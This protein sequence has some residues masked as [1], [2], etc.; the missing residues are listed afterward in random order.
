MYYLKGESM[1]IKVVEKIKK[2]LA[3]SESSNEHEAKVSLL[4]AQELLAKHKLSLKEVKEFKIYNNSIKE[5][6]STVS[7]TKAKWKAKLARVIA[8]NFGCYYYFKTRRS[9][10]IAFFGREE[11]TLV[12]NIV[13]EYAVDCI[14]SSVRKLRYRYS[15]DG[16]STKGLEND[17]A[18]GFIKG[19]NKMFEEQ[20]RSNQ[21]WGLVLVKDAEVVEAHENIK[22][23]GSVDTKTQ[24]EGYSEV[25]DQGYKD[26]EDFSI[27]DKIAEGETEEQLALASGKINI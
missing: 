14:N 7:F 2:L 22:F 10:T 20:K 19:L 9:H 17:Y 15:R 26:G 4:K 21:E 3:L 8:D 5:K 27:S 25:Y 23:K 13:L 6:V 18:L 1:D 12:C 11:D 16:Y 24:F